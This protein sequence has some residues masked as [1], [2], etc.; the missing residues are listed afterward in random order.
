MKNINKTH[1][2][3]FHIFIMLLSLM[4]H[5][6]LLVRLQEGLREVQV[7]QNLG[8]PRVRERVLLLMW[9]LRLRQGPDG[10]QILEP[11]YEG[12]R[13]NQ[14]KNGLKRMSSPTYL[15]SWQRL[16]EPCLKVKATHHRHHIG[17]PTCTTWTNRK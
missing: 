16:S 17:N 4:H 8:G 3:H 9:E 2:F 7:P 13:N 6:L 1:I 5:L 15:V 11:Q 10:D 12:D 14:R